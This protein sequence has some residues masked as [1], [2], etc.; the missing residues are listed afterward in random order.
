MKPLAGPSIHTRFLLMCVLIC[1]LCLPSRGLAEK[2]EDHQGGLKDGLQGKIFER[3]AEG[4]W[5]IYAAKVGYDRNR[6]VYEAEGS[7]RITSGDKMI[8]AD[9]AELDTVSRTV[10][11]R[12]HVLLKFKKDWVRGDHVVWNLDKETGTIDG[13][14]A[15]FSENNFYASGKHIAKTGATQY[16]MQDGFVTS[17]DPDNAD[18]KFKYG[19]MTVDLNG[20][21]VAR[22]SSFWVSK[23]PILYWPWIS[24][25]VK[26]ERQSGLLIPWGGASE[27][28]GIEGEIPFYWAISKDMDATFYGRFMAERGWMTGAEYRIANKT[29]GEGI[30]AVNY[31][32][33]MADKAHLQDEGYPFQTSDRFWLRAKHSVDLPHNIEVRLDLD[34]VSDSN[35]LKEFG[36]GSTSFDYSDKMFRDFL[37][38]GILN[39]ET[40]SAR[41]SALYVD[42]RGESTQLSLDVRYW[43]QTDKSI[44]EF[45]LQR[46]PAV[47]FNVV[48]SRID[49]LPLYYTLESSWVDYWR[50]EGDTGNRV[51]LFPRAY[52]PLHWKSYLD[53]EPSFGLRNTA[54]SVDWDGDSHGQWQERMLSDVR[55]EMSS[56]LNRVY[57]FNVWNMVAFQHAIR[58]EIIYEYT[59]TNIE[60]RIPLFDRLDEDQSR[61]DIRFGF[62]SFLTGK[63][64]LKD[65]EG[66]TA[67]SFREL[68]RLELFQAFNLD[69][70][71][72][73]PRFD[74]SPVDGFSTVGIRLDVTPKKHVTLSYD[75]DFSP[76]QVSATQHD[77]F[78]TFDSSLGHMFRLDYRYRKD[79]VI[80]GI[81]V[82]NEII[83]RLDIK[84]LPDVYITTYHDYSIDKNDLFAHGYGVKYMHGCWGVGVSY[85]E[86]AS[87]QRIAFSLNLLGLG[88]FGGS[89]GYKTGENPSAVP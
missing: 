2:T 25:P 39:D 79:A 89:Y 70:P 63:E 20:N 28:N 7:V 53:I 46:L 5:K 10:E 29:W 52:Y 31:L 80:E 87:D 34:V 30:W 69:P 9:W 85:E 17:C 50:R 19:N 71:L 78:L 74:P 11:L 32:K 60:D 57:D 18:W 33:D 1:A 84:V 67:T 86:E 13:G 55:L 77:L 26:E 27:L 6:K 88:W 44:D 61:H 42:Q 15:Y 62:S 43:D 49:G 82:I 23:V 75:A 83:P 64:V 76:E 41:E 58:P 8:E 48:P 40:I 24:L 12:G 72:P 81:P 4:L 22:D 54:Y 73:D 21:A 16:E 14:L 3:S 45:T 36:K 66:N 59:S 37:G 47:A 35:Y 38:R 51:D 65:T 56:R 68:A